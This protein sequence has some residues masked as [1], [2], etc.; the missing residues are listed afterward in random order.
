MNSKNWQDYEQAYSLRSAKYSGG[1]FLDITRKHLGVIEYVEK[2]IRLFPSDK[3]AFC[4]AGCGNGIYLK[5]FLN[6]HQEM[7]L[8]GFD[9]SEDI[10]EI[11][12]QNTGLEIKAGNLEQAPFEDKKFNIIL[13]TQVIEHMLDDKKAMSEL[14]RMLKPGG[15]L[16]LSTD[17]KGNIVTKI[18]NFPFKI[19]AYPIKF[20]RKREKAQEFFPHRDYSMDEFKDLI[21]N[22]EFQIIKIGTFRFSL[23][24]P[25]YKVKFLRTPLNQ[26]EK[27]SAKL[28]WFE[29]NGD[30]VIAL[31]KKQDAILQSIRTR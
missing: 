26:F 16:I 1:T 27:L 11:A 13:C 20:F 24:W 9:F 19:I 3:L 5:Y 31:C 4:D 8:F 12:K 28:G 14:Y 21:A 30:I 6:N 10:V 7:Q 22:Q 29:N 2:A 17:N 18:L 25:F 15:Y 23:P